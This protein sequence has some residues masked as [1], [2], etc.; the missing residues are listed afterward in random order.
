[1]IVDSHA[2]IFPFLG[3]ESGYSSAEEHLRWLQLYMVRHN[4]PV[5]KVA[6]GSLVGD[7]QLADLPLDD[8]AKLNDV[9]FRVE[10]NGRFVWD[11]EDGEQYIQFMPPSLQTTSSGP[12]YL[13][14][15]MAHAGVDMAVLQNAHLYGCL[16]EYFAAAVAAH[17][18]K[19]VGLAQ[20]DEVRADQQVHTLVQAVNEMGLA[21]LYF[22]NR[23]Y[24]H[25]G[26]SYSYDDDRFEGFWST[27]SELGVPV[28]W[29]V[30]A[31]PTGSGRSVL[32]E[33]GRLVR[34]ASRYP[35]I[36]CVFTHGFSPEVVLGD[37]AGPI[38]ELFRS[39]QFLVEILYPIRWGRHYAYPYSELGPV[40]R[41]V[42]RRVGAHRLV[43]GSDM[44]NVGRNCTYR[45][46]R[47]YLLHHLS[48]LGTPEIDGILGGN[49]AELF[50]AARSGTAT[51]GSLVQTPLLRPDHS[52]PREG[53]NGPPEIPLITGREAAR[54]ASPLQKKRRVN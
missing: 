47:E 49:I 8:I 20:V 44:P 19:F 24:V 50:R 33:L 21:G 9:G 1:M 12:E 7:P 38:A 39:D 18:G 32:P 15:E 31:V 37:L 41:E 3:S 46:S 36:R 51:G 43:W 5:H 52:R 16:N 10:R 22:A 4:Q 35:E 17:P 40:I 6:D 11:G 45:Q 25:C 27:V 29:E 13:L 53:P 54:N 28:F 2:H 48:S 30:S 26:Y 23:A 42:Y 34:W 14:A